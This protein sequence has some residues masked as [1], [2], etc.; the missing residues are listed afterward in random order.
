MRHSPIDEH[1]RRA[2][3]ESIVCDPPMTAAQKRNGIRKWRV[4]L[5]KLSEKLRVQWHR[6]QTRR[7]NRS[8][9]K[10]VSATL[11]YFKNSAGHDTVAN[12]EDNPVVGSGEETRRR[13]NTSEGGRTP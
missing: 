3:R 7:T 6:R 13:R 4:A 11:L 12:G 5:R 2:E 9:D 8:I 10:I 1:P